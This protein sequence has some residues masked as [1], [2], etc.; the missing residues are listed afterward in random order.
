MTSSQ[1]V[2]RQTANI[3][4][5][6]ITEAEDVRTRAAIAEI[7][8]QL[9][10]MFKADNAAFRYDKFFPACRLDNWGE[11]REAGNPMIPGC[12]RPRSTE[13]ER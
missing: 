9:A 8:K 3:I 1:R 2:Y 10:D 7:A 12:L 5:A 6:A 11:L 13:N 4:A